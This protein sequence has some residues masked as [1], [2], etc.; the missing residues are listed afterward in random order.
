MA[1]ESKVRLK[2]GRFVF[3]MDMPSNMI[4]FIKGFIPKDGEFVFEVH[5]EEKFFDVDVNEIDELLAEV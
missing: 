4:K 1:K 3:I 5:Q 2:D